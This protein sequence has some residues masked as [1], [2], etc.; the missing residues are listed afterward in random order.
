MS[1]E[2]RVLGILL[3]T[4]PGIIKMAPLFHAAVERGVT[5]V[6]IHSGQHYSANLDAE[7]WH[8]VQLPPPDRRVTR[9]VDANSHAEVTAAML[10]GIERALGETG[11]TDFCVCGDANTNLAGALAARKVH[12]RVG[13]V[14]AGL[15]SDDW[16]MPEE[17]NR[18]MIDHI[19][20]VLFAPT[21]TAAERLR[22]E[23]VRGTIHVV[24]NTVVDSC[25][26]H[27]PTGPVVPGSGPIVLTMHREENVDTPETLDG[28]L[29]LAARITELAG[30][31]AVFPAHP[32]TLR[33]IQEFG[34]HHRLESVA[35]SIDVVAPLGY[36]A[37]LEAIARAPL[38][39][40]DSG[41]LQEEACI[42]GTPCYTLR[43]STERPETVEVGANLIL[44]TDLRCAWERY[45]GG[46]IVLGTVWRNPFGDGHAA[47]RII[48]AMWGAPAGQPRPLRSA[49][50][51][52]R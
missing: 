48:E 27:R 20:E 49:T 24:G 21:D 25:R 44:G 8:E 1:Q 7:I 2:P 26:R 50:A 22:S 9:P 46:K 42:L 19:S 40:T 29:T 4:R 28:L 32:R 52:V 15:R 6:L 18:V 11:V 33:R 3:G 30:T 45:L 41:G 34:L 43:E 17:H 31:R 5:P 36:R 16:R 23:R 35:G 37:M 10:V 38:L 13:H 51:S 12:V 39:L 14:E 47:E